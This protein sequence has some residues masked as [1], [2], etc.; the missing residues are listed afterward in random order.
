MVVVWCL[1]RR[2]KVE[3]SLITVSMALQGAAQEWLWW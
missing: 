2:K 3:E 1:L